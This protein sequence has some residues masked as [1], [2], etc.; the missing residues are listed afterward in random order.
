MRVTRLVISDLHLAD[1]IF[2]L[3]GFGDRQQAALLRLLSGS[4]S[5]EQV[6]LIINGDC[7]D[8]LA[9]TPYNLRR[10]IDP[11]LALQKI[12]KIIAAHLPFFIALR[13]FLD[14]PGRSLTFVAGNHDPEL[15]FVAVQQRICRELTG[16]EQNAR[17]SFCTSRI[18]RPVPDVYLEHGHRYDFWNRS[19]QGVWD[20]QGQPLTLDLQEILLPF[21]SLYYQLVLSLIS[22]RYPFFDH[23]EPGMNR[24][25]QIG[26]LCL[27]DP[28]FVVELARRTMRMLSYSRQALAHLTGDEAQE[29][30]RL[31]DEA[32]Q[33]FQAFRHDI[34]S[35][36]EPTS[37]PG[38]SQEDMQE[39]LT[40]RNALTLPLV[41]AVRVLC[42]P[43][44]EQDNEGVTPDM[45]GI[46]LQDPALRY[47]IAGHTHQAREDVLNGGAQRYFNSGSWTDRYAQPGPAEIT[48]D[49]VAWLRAPDWRQIPLRDLTRLTFIEL[50]TENSGSTQARLRA[51]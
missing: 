37:A 13:S 24:T 42:T 2:P 18:Y 6:E 5:A 11:A 38:V 3:D 9:T 39:F 25:R 40:V 26:L 15:C 16:W 29:P 36:M 44:V 17:V 41:E 20:E 19:V 47:A 8:F 48:P 50:I 49:L 21:G 22:Q 28:A 14:R 12:E 45:H 7:F 23:W 32:M 1:G 34:Q 30:V 51:L 43:S 33:D 35:Q 4:E 27:F 46:L 31:F 10:A